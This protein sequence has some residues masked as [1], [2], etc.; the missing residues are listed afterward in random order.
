VALTGSKI[1]PAPPSINL[2]I[3]VICESS[4]VVSGRLLPRVFR[5]IRGY[6]NKIFQKIFTPFLTSSYENQESRIKDFFRPNAQVRPT[7]GN[8]CPVGC[9]VCYPIGVFFRSGNPLGELQITNS[10]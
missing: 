1:S 9:A 6:K 8:A 2:N 7:K 3:F 5:E 4:G 10:K